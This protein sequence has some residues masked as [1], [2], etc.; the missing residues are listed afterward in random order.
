[1]EAELRGGDVAEHNERGENRGIVGG[2]IPPF[3]Y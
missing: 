2:H 1:M 3:L